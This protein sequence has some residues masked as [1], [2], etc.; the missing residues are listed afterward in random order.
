MK[1]HIFGKVLNMTIPWDQ[2]AELLMPLA[3][4]TSD[5]GL[6][7]VMTRVAGMTLRGAVK[8]AIIQK[9][10]T[11]SKYVVRLFDGSQEWYWPAIIE[12]YKVMD[13][14]YKN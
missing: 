10:A 11:Q 9:S 1:F 12:L 4:A 7:P 3:V 5:G 13:D 14:V 6:A 8:E 2:S